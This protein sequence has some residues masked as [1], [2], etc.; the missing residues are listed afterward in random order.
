ML[1]TGAK[2]ITLLLERQGVEV[3][4]GIPG[5]SV[6]PLYD[7]LTSSTIRHILVRHEQAAGFLAQGFSRSRGIPG[8]CIAT[9]GPG[10]MNLLTAVADA[11]SDR[12]QQS[13]PKYFPD[14]FQN[15]NQR[16]VVCLL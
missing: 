4:A 13:T 14:A 16:V 3:V 12:F 15:R 10:A 7:A 9:S 11:G 8:V 5:G 1:V 2:L 6:L